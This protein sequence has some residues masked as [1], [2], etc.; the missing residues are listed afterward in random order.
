MET[1]GIA[2]DLYN[3][4]EAEDTGASPFS[5]DIRKF[6]LP[7]KFNVPRFI[8]YD[9]TSD[10][11]A[12]LRH[13]IQRMSVWDDDDFL[14]SRVFSSGLGDLPLQWF[15]SLPEGSISSWRR[16]RTS[17]LEK[18]QAHQVIPKMDADLMALRMREDEN[19]TQFARRF[20]TVY[21]QV[22][23]SFEEL[24]VKSF[25]QALRL[26]IELR[27]QLVMYPVA[28]MKELM[29]RANRFIRAEEDKVQGRE[30]FVLSQKDRPSKGD[31]RS[32]RREDRRRDSS[33]DRHRAS[34]LDRRRAQ[35]SDRHRAPFT[36]AAAL[37]S[38][39]KSR[40][41]AATFKV[42]NTVFK[43]SI[44]KLLS[45][46]KTQ[47]FFK[48]PQPM[49]GDSSSRDQSKFCAYHKQ[50]GHRTEDCKT[51]KAHLE[52]LV[53]EG[54]LRDHIREEGRDNSRPLRQDDGSHDSEPEGIIIVIHL[55]PP[56][57]GSS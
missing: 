4:F 7:E 42:M 27:A 20:W 28:T 26:G 22:E 31:K 18:F 32:S 23:S 40:C 55:A 33:L 45:K 14:N 53:K 15:C 24:V 38:G 44:Y 46:I 37:G 11:A 12:H 39:G 56:P 6:S 9:G 17:F 29:A 3:T 8:L 36:S 5:R 1:A 30:N 50:N 2:R 47:P 35:S 57:K 21:S 34:S 25:Q 43:E 48:W 54:H 19:V 41:E 10:P 51:F 52:N 16:L 13:F 49:R